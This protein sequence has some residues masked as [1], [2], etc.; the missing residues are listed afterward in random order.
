MNAQI[1][2]YLC[3]AF[4]SVDRSMGVPL[5]TPMLAETTVRMTFFLVSLSPGG[6][7]PK[8]A[9]TW[10]VRGKGYYY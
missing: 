9:F 2:S 6:V 5:L 3:L 8:P 1:D 4:E 10:I 7:S